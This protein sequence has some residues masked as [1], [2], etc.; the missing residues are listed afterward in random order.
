VTFSGYVETRGIRQRGTLWLF[1]QSFWPAY[2]D[3]IVPTYRNGSYSFEEK[4]GQVLRLQKCIR[5]EGRG[6]QK[7]PAG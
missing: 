6:V 1:C 2:A 5:R 4:N 3:D 7:T